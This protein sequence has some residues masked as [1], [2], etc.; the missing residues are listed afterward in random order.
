V[1]PE[2]VFVRV[3]VGTGGTKVVAEA[4]GVLVIDGVR[5]KIN[6]WLGVMVSPAAVGTGVDEDV[7][8]TEA[9]AVEVEEGVRLGV[10]VW[11]RNPGVDVRVGSKVAVEVREAVEVSEGVPVRVRVT[12]VDGVDVEVG[13]T[14]KVGVRVYVEVNVVV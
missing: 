12:V 7:N 3:A 4:V 11:N 13:V 5:E 2:G 10:C 9:A 8:V 1:H 14:E 6:V